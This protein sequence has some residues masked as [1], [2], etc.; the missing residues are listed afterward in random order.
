MSHFE[1]AMAVYVLASWTYTAVDILRRRRTL[2][3]EG[4][5]ELATMGARMTHRLFWLGL[6]AAIITSPV[7]LPFEFFA[8]YCPDNDG[9]SS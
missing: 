6:F 5:E 9:G 2:W 1:A 4:D 3:D 7:I 8:P